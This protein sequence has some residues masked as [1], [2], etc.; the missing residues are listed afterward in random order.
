[1]ALFVY[2]CLTFDL[3]GDLRSERETLGS[4][5]GV[6][7]S[8]RVCPLRALDGTLG[9]PKLAGILNPKPMK[10]TV[11]IAVDQWSDTIPFSMTSIVPESVEK[12]LRE[13]HVP[14]FVYKCLTSER[15]PGV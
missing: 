5:R 10:V 12:P 7:L 14:L 9:N 2:K 1:M 8:D 6:L 15:D 13:R 3:S 11:Y 4:R